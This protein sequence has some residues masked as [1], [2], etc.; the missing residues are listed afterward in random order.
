MNDAG[1][2]NQ[3]ALGGNKGK[4]GVLSCKPERRREIIG[5]I[6]AAKKRLDE[7]T[8]FGSNGYFRQETDC[9]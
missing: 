5:K 6:R 4:F 3:L 1:A 2:V 7:Q 9:S 8:E